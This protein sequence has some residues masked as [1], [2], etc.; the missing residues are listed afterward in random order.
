MKSAVCIIILTLRYLTSLGVRPNTKQLSFLGVPWTATYDDMSYKYCQYKSGGWCGV[1]R[2]R[3]PVYAECSKT[4]R[5][6]A[7]SDSKTSPSLLSGPAQSPYPLTNSP[8][9]ETQHQGTTQS[10]HHQT[11]K[12]STGNKVFF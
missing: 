8:H 12:C 5:Y 6:I 10:D 1:E 2:F 9:Q 11:Q 7:G 4:C 3:V